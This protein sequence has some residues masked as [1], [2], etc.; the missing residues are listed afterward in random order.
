[1]TSSEFDAHFARL[2]N[3]F[4]MSADM[5]RDLEYEEWARSIR[6]FHVDAFDD[7]VTK[8]IREAEDIFWPPMNAVIE[9]IRSRIVTREHVSHKCPTCNGATWIE[10]LP[11]KSNGHVYTGY[12]R[13]PDCGVPPPNYKP[14]EFRDELTATEYAQYL[15]GELHSPPIPIARV[16]GRAPK[17]THTWEKFKAPSFESLKKQTRDPGEEG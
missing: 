14:H 3:H 6:H 1:M 4:K 17:T 9:A 7:A 5:N 12:A 15:Q 16:G 13:C 8:V 10:G 2:E 11:W